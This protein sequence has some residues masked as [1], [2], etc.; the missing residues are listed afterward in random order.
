LSE[1][2]PTISV[3]NLGTQGFDDTIGADDTG[4]ARE[5]PGCVFVDVNGFVNIHRMEKDFS[6]SY[7]D[8]IGSFIYHESSKSGN[9]FGTLRGHAGF[10]QN[11]P[12]TQVAG[13][14]NRT[15]DYT[16]WA[17]PGTS[18]YITGEFFEGKA[19]SAMGHFVRNST[20]Y[21]WY[22]AADFSTSAVASE[23]PLPL[24]YY[25]FEV[26]EVPSVTTTHTVDM[27]LQGVETKTHTV[28]MR[29]S[30]AGSVQ[31]SVDQVI[32]EQNTVSHS[33]DQ[34]IIS[35][36]TQTHTV[37]MV[38]SEIIDVTVNLSVATNMS[39]TV[40]VEGP[41]PIVGKGIIG[42]SPDSHSSGSSG[43]GA[44]TGRIRYTTVKRVIRR[45]G[46]N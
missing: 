9:T 33:V 26:P 44:G 18:G 41:P 31:H 25:V 4:V 17:Y 42:G 30:S 19:Y 45:D 21:V 20:D 36:V 14:Q 10:Y 12:D 43:G 5:Q 11:P 27:G 46:R 40:E 13:Q 29:L 1:A 15:T 2:D 6:G 22:A 8:G 37:D 7:A 38:L 32:V 35:V 34:R 24:V 16:E 39:V 23:G 3:S 28:D